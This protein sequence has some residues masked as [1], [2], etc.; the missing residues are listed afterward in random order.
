M[1]QFIK[2]ISLDPAEIL[3]NF[4]HTV[5]QSVAN[6]KGAPPYDPIFFSI[7]CSFSENLSKLYVT[8]EGWPPPTGD[9]GFV[10]DKKPKFPFLFISRV[11]TFRLRQNAFSIIHE[12]QIFTP[13]RNNYLPA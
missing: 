11:M 10:P 6:L 8:P 2:E 9:P 13:R 5:T 4:R 7:S 3:E 12:T 1:L